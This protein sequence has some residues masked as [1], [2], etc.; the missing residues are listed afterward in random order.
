M[1]TP[2][3]AM[4]HVTSRCVPLDTTTVPL[5]LALGHALAEDIRVP[6]PLP[7]FDNSAMDGFAVR[8]HNT[9]A[10]VSGNPVRLTI[11]S[12]VYAGARK[13]TLRSGQACRIMT[14]APLPRG[15]DAVIPV[16]DVL[17]DAGALVIEEPVE[18]YRHVRRRGEEVRAGARIVKKGTLVHPGVIACLASV[19]R[20]DV[21]VVRRPRVAVIATGDEMVSPGGALDDGQIY[22]SNSHM[23]TAML[24]QMGIQPARVRSVGDRRSALLSAVRSALDRCDVLVTSGGVSMGEH[25]FLRSVLDELG[26]EEVFWRVRQK[27]GKP[28]YFGVRD[29]KYVFGLPG[30]PASAFVCFYVYVYAALERLSGMEDR[31]GLVEDPR[32][33]TDAF[34]ADGKR[35][36]LLRGQNR[37]VCTGQVARL[38]RQASHMV[39]TLADTDCLIVVPGDGARVRRGQTLPTLRLPHAREKR[40]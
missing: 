22:D 39:T 20:N 6:F 24:H 16:E 40:K 32:A 15:A 8:S 19:G 35:W 11:K 13:G 17:V 4:R 7:R 9:A 18:K 3:Q 38:P 23:L 36:L 33:I 34:T 5:D 26:V 30:N 27:P 1:I 10:A 28:L 14:G 21:S 25:D 2:Q 12:T 29:R 31:A 37:D